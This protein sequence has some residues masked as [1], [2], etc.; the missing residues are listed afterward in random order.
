MLN[1][2]QKI[3]NDDSQTRLS[4][5]IFFAVNTAK[6]TANRSQLLGLF[7]GPRFTVNTVKKT[8]DW[9]Q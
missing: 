1:S 3:I 2:G 4:S 7:N 6:F 9:E 5:I 8:E